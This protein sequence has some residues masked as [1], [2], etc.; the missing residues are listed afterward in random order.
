M[1]EVNLRSFDLNLLT[2]LKALLDE[3]HVTRAADKIG[4]SQPAMSRALARLRTMFQDPLLVKTSNGLGMTHRA[5]DLHQSLNQVLTD[6]Q[7]LIASPEF[8][9]ANISRE[10]TIATRDYESAVLLPDIIS[11]VTRKA[12]GIT[13]RIVS[14]QGDDLTPLDNI[15]VDFVIAGSDVSFSTLSRHVLYHEN[16]TCLAAADHPLRHKKWTLAA[17]LAQQHCLVTIKN[18]GLGLVDSILAKQKLKRNIAVR[19]SHFMSAAHIVAKT[20]LITTVPERLGKL[21]AD[22]NSIVM[23]KPPINIPSFPIYL[24]WHIRNHHNP[25]HQWLRTEMRGL[26]K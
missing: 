24:Y 5:L 3:K 10:I 21:M 4:M 18:V 14:L 8:E 12:P 19:V 25:L 23:L 7:Q 26:F 11:S 1:R 15:D 13:F 20:D 17:Y 9:P 22:N 2:A 16:F 6:V